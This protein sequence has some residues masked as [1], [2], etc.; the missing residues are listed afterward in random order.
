MVVGWVTIFFRLLRD[1]KF[2][3]GPGGGGSVF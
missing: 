1:V 2:L 3:V